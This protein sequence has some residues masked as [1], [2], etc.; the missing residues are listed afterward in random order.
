MGVWEPQ[1]SGQ[2]GVAL[3][4]Q[5]CVL[6]TRSCS[7]PLKPRLFCM[8]TDPSGQRLE[9]KPRLWLSALTRVSQA[10]T[11]CGRAVCSTVGCFH[12][13]DASSGSQYEKHKIPPDIA[14]FTPE[15]TLLPCSLNIVTKTYHMGC[16]AAWCGQYK[17]FDIM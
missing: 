17:A 4:T 10:N 12:S 6:G 9:F 15:D 13:R 1:E 16:Q 2:G 8:I 11:I 7:H 5:L 14:K 3:G